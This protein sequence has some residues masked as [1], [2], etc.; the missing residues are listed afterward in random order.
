MWD[1]ANVASAPL[2]HVS[3]TMSLCLPRWHGDGIRVAGAA[4]LEDGANL[5]GAKKG[6]YLD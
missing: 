4:M 5:S 1:G 2:C 6:P 3:P